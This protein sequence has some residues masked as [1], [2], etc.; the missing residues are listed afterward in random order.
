[1]EEDISLHS[2][3]YG[4]LNLDFSEISQNDMLRG[5]ILSEILSKPKAFR[6]GR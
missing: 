6:R 5:I 4:T 2:A 3:S 1:M